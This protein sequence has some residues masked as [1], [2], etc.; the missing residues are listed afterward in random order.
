[1]K[2]PFTIGIAFFIIV[3]QAVAQM[4][5]ADLT[6][7]FHAYQSSWK[8]TKIQL[9]INQ[10]KYSP[11]DTVWFKAYFLDADLNS[12]PGKQKIYVNLIDSH[13]DSKVHAIINLYDGL[14]AN[15]IYLPENLS[16]GIYLLTAYSNWM[17]NFNPIPLFKKEITIVAKNAVI[18]AET[19][20]LA[21][22]VEGGHIVRDV[23]NRI[24]FRGAPAGSTV[25]LVDAISGTLSG[26]TR[27]DFNGL[28]A[29]V[30]TPT[31][32]GRYRA[33]LSGAPGIQCALPPTEEDGCAVMLEQSVAEGTVIRIRTPRESRLRAKRLA[34]VV[35]CNGKIA[36]TE[37][38]TPGA[39]GSNEIRIKPAVMSGRV[40]HLSL[41]DDTGELLASRDFYGGEEITAVARISAQTPVFHPREEVT[42]YVSLADQRGQ[43]IQG[44]FSISVINGPLFEKKP[45]NSLADELNILVSNPNFTIDRSDADWLAAVNNYLL[46]ETQALPWKKILSDHPMKPSFNFTN[47]IVMQGK[48][49][50]GDTGEPVPEGTRIL[51]YLQRDGMHYETFT[52]GA[53]NVRI[54]LPDVFGADEFFYIAET[55]KGKEIPVIKIRWDQDTIPQPVAR[56][57][58]ET[59]TP[60][61]YASFI[62]KTR[63]IKRSFDFYTGRAAIG[64]GRAID[65][66]TFEDE[67]DG[68]DIDVD[69]R[70]YVAMTSM[71]ELL[72]EV[73]PSLYARQSAGE[74][75]VRV[76][77]SEPLFPVRG[78]PV[79]IIDGIAT[80]STAF[81]LSL[82]PA[83]ILRVKV[84]TDPK[85]L[86]PYKLMG[87]NGIVIVETKTGDVREPLD[88][89]GKVIAGVNKEMP[90][91]GPD[92]SRDPGHRI[93]D[94]RSTVYWNPS[95]KTDA[96]GKAVVHFTCSDDVA[97]MRI[98]VD[99]I[100]EGGRPFSAVLTVE[101]QEN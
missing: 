8:E 50:Y 10:E 76:N 45:A 96:A 91:Q 90:F 16:A 64:E 59:A 60:D 57:S 18:A 20:A 47:A 11:G 1:M 85:K 24:C 53:G 27:I 86:M 81:F 99:G 95:V 36:D 98:R 87:K 65:I 51:F 14:G 62:L 43:P 31:S 12:I 42:V 89:A 54:T 52:V 84:V 44:E 21:V 92:F 23:P 75:R 70:D 38:F 88:D 25:E 80:K 93:P 78:D 71:A 41:L 2:K 73:V 69:V 4:D 35:S 34:L 74:S 79:Y 30:F 97:P 17:K 55:R 58:R 56:A 100:A 72:R 6:S 77:L 48:A 83:D 5:V 68:A 7:R 15:E 82:N 3:S 67:I 63:Q 26:H 46:C 61:P 29:L 22:F 39:D 49:R 37:T 19:P 66:P 33:Q 28:G 40:A 101:V 9:V 32:G 13:G 94:F